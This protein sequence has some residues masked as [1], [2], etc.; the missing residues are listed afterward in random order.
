MRIPG[1]LRSARFVSRPNRFL[2]V[3]ELDGEPVEAHLPDPGRLKE[4]LL[5]GANVWVR[6]A[7]GPGRKTR[8][9]L[10]MVEAPSG[11]LVSVVTTLPNEL[12][13]EALEAGRIAELA[14][15]RVAGL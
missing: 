5:P 13:A 4:L 12:V 1:P 10:A 14:E 9:T 11:E 8:F 3:V 15:S 2:T 7:S 6:P